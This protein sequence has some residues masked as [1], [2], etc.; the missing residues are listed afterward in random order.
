MPDLKQPV[1]VV[2]MK[3]SSPRDGSLVK[4]AIILLFDPIVRG[5]DRLSSK[6]GFHSKATFESVSTT[7]DDV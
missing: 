3:H 1:N 6:T 4:N 2:S 5:E 7:I